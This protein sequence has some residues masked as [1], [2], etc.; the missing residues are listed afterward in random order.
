M[1]AC[2]LAWMADITFID[3]SISASVVPTGASWLPSPTC[4]SAIE[5][6]LLPSST[7][8]PSNCANVPDGSLNGKG[9]RLSLIAPLGRSMSLNSPG[10]MGVSSP[11]ILSPRALKPAGKLDKVPASIS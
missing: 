11:L 8:T 6:N 7:K 3:L 4:R 5:A 9:I 2:S 1:L 10:D